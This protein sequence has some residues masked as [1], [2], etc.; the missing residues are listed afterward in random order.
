MSFIRC[1]TCLMPSTRPSTA[2]VDGECSAC[3]S[4]RNRKEVDWDAREQELIRILEQNKGRAVVASS[5]GK[6]SHFIALKLLELGAKVTIVTATTDHLTDIGR[7]NINNLARYADTIEVTPNQ[8]VRRKIAR[9]GLRTV[10]DISHGEHMA[11]WATPFKMATRLGIPL[12]FYGENPQNDIGGPLGA[13]Q[14]KTM[15]RRWISEFGGLLGMR[16]RDLIG[17]DGITEFD[18]QPYM[19]PSD[20]EMDNVTAYFLGQFVPWDGLHNAVYARKRGF[21]WYHKEVEGSLG[22]YESL[23]NAQ[24]GLH[25]WFKFLKYGYMRPTDMASLAIRRERITRDEGT[26][27]I[28]A[29]EKFPYTYIGVPYDEVIDRI[30][31]TTSEFTDICKKFT[32]YS[33]FLED[34]DSWKNPVRS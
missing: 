15:T 13:D 11:I 24:T 17:V 30:G 9:H 12:V 8:E 23:D 4:F 1:K 10:G 3:I 14:A 6:D 21:E 33:I 5:G 16:A 18:M 34:A 7:R 26:E 32:N 28:D 2:F 25:E 20:D 19:L 27:I 29:K 22:K 31:V